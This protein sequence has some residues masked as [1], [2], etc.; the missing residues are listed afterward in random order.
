MTGLDNFQHEILAAFFERQ[1]GFFLTGGAALV[2]FH[3]Q[4]RTTL[5]LDLFT[6]EDLMDE[7]EQALVEIA[8]AREIDLERLRTSTDFRRFL[9]TRGTESLVVDLV[10]DLSPQI[11]EEK[12][13]IHGIRVDSPREIM[14]N[15]LCTL[16]SR[17]ELRDLVDVRAL[18]RE[19]LSIEEHLPLAAAKDA[20]LTAGQLAWVLSQIEIGDDA[21]PPGNVSAAELQSFV[22]SLIRRLTS[23]AYPD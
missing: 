12:P 22:E 4:H 1:R 15:K 21:T 10:R 20:G 9:L 13:E 11:D 2:G 18:D 16:L 6:N 17:A 19:G 7:G 23:M 5:D 14:A 8:R 3:L